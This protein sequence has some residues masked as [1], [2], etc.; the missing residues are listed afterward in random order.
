[1]IQNDQASSEERGF[2]HF[3]MIVMTM[4][5]I[6]LIHLTMLRDFHEKV[7]EHVSIHIYSNL[8]LTYPWHLQINITLKM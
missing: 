2:Y 3:V 4:D 7:G 1:M 8:N 5:M 6:K